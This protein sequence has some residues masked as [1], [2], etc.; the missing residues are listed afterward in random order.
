MLAVLVFV[1]LKSLVLVGVGFVGWDVFL[2]DEYTRHK[3]MDKA[4]KN[5]EIFFIQVF[6]AIKKPKIVNTYQ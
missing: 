6:Y 4:A 1:K 3:I 5:R 2:H